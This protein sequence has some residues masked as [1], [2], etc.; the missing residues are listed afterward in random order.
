MEYKILQPERRGSMLL[1]TISRPESMNALNTAFFDEMDYLIANKAADPTLTAVVI[2]G[3]G[4]AFVA[5]ADISE[6][7]NK[8]G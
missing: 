6:M 1:V 5:G 7:V 8:T 2:T 4:K 3:T